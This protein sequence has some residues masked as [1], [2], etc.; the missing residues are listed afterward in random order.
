[1]LDD[2]RCNA[3][4]RLF[5]K[6]PILIEVLHLDPNRP[7]D[8]F[9]DT[10]NGKAPLLHDVTFVGFIEEHRIDHDPFEILAPGVAAV[11]FSEW[12]TIHHKQTEGLTNLGCS[13]P[14]TFRLVHRFPH[15]FNELGKPFHVLIHIVR[16]LPEHGI[17]ISD[18]RQYHGANLRFARHSAR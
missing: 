14:D 17:A 6:H 12:R 2:A 3:T 4:Q 11:P 15:V 16:L 8:R 10:G 13:Q 1:M 5:T 7:L 18:Y 9:P